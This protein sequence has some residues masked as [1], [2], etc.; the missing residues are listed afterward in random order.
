VRVTQDEIAA[1]GLRLKGWLSGLNAVVKKG[2]SPEFTVKG[3]CT[4]AVRTRYTGTSSRRSGNRAF[5]G[6]EKFTLSDIFAE[7]VATHKAFDIGVTMVPA[8][9]ALVAEISGTTLPLAKAIELF[10]GVEEWFAEA[11]IK[12]SENAPAVDPVLLK[13]AI[14]KTEERAEWGAW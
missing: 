8:D 1:Q 5:M 10:D 13:P 9:T 6:G 12:A 2:A 11:R 3:P 7:L 4:F 14:E